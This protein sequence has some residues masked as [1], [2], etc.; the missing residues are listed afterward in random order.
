MDDFWHNWDNWDIWDVWDD[1]FFSFYQDP[2][3]HYLSIIASE[4]TS[5]SLPKNFILDEP[6]PWKT[7]IF[8]L[9]AN[10]LPSSE[11]NVKRNGAA[12]VRLPIVL[13]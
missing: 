12:S 4:R 13:A 10:G 5:M 8:L 3:G 2:Y 6:K 1:F 7:R 9:S 11:R